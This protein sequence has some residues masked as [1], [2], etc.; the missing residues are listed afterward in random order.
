MTAIAAAPR[1]R[2]AV[3]VLGLLAVCGVVR[4]AAAQA[5]STPAAGPQRIHGIYMNGCIAGAQPLPLEGPGYEVIRVSRN[6]Y[7][8]HARA[9]EFV[10]E[11]GR[12]IDRLGLSHVYIGDISQP[13][14]GRMSFGHASH[15]VGLDID[16]WF[17]QSKRPRI[18]VAKREEPVLRSLVLKG[19]AGIDDAVW[20]P[21][22]A[23]LLRTAAQAPEVDR[24]FVNKWIKHRLCETTTGDRAWLRK[25]V[26]WYYHDA[27]FHVRL[28]C[29]PGDRGCVAQAPV[30]SGDGC[31]K[32]LADWFALPDPSTLPQGPAIRPPKPPAACETVLA[33]P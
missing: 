13:R 4:P 6:R 32:A 27:H 33:G 3:A 10:R 19:E 21:A 20:Q 2:R 28:H 29:P 30:P 5:P 23:I 24:I 16:I 22:H 14:G 11:F 18:P 25:I 17:E 1:F 7:W 12:A 9:V 31:G 15:Q 8:G 26:P